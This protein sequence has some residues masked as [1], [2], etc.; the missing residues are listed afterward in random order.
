MPLCQHLT[1]TF[2]HECWLDHGERRSNPTDDVQK[3]PAYVYVARKPYI[4]F[5]KSLLD[6]FQFFDFRD[7]PI[8]VKDTRPFLSCNK[9]ELHSMPSAPESKVAGAAGFKLGASEEI[10]TFSGGAPY[11]RAGLIRWVITSYKPISSEERSVP[12][13]RR[14]ISAGCS[15][16]WT[17]MWSV[18]WA[19]ILTLCVM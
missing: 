10:A 1:K 7:L 3:S 2:S 8:L 11:R 6:D 18:C 4:I 15:S 9:Q 16:S 14:K 5:T 17:R 13:A 19:A 12:F